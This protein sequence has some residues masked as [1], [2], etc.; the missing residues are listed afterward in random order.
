MGQSLS[1]PAVGNGM[2][3]E[4][5]KVRFCLSWGNQA[6]PFQYRTLLLHLSLCFSNDSSLPSNFIQVC[7]GGPPI[8]RA[9]PRVHLPHPSTSVQISHLP[10]SRHPQG[11][12]CAPHPGVSVCTYLHSSSELPFKVLRPEV[13]GPSPSLGQC[14]PSREEMQRLC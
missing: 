11:P 2:V 3:G 8:R 14:G 9:L 6:V 5:R 1:H 4:Q 7:F 13:R 10:R 12:L